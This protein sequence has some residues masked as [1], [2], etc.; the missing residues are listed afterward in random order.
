MWN[1]ISDELFFRYRKIECIHGHFLPYKY[2]DFYQT[3]GHTFVTWFRDPVERLAS[4][5]Y[6]WKEYHDK[7]EK[8]PLLEKFLEEDWTFEE[9]VFSEEVRNIYSLFLWNFPVERFKFIGITEFYDEDL[10]FFARNFLEISEIT[11]PKKNVNEK[12]KEE[13]RIDPGLERDIKEFH[14]EDYKLYEYAL[15]QRTKRRS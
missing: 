1:R 8:Q 13:K 15:K 6:Y 9:F 14:A 4:H 12:S 11:I 10:I 7:M 2:E 5:Y 3:G